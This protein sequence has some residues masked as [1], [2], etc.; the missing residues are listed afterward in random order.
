MIGQYENMAND[1]LLRPERVAAFFM[2]VQEPCNTSRQ[3]CRRA[4]TVADDQF[5]GNGFALLLML[6]R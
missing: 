2:G 3:W 1:L 6:F 5:G 4:G